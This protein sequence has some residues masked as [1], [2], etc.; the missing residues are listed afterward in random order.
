MTKSVKLD[1][2]LESRIQHLAE[3]RQR[4]PHWIMREAIQQYVDREEKREA[5]R[6]DALNAWEAYQETGLHV[7][8]DEAIAW[9]ETWG[10]E[11][12]K[13]APAC[14]KTLKSRY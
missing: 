13:P 5:F 6:R 7:T 12:E 9:L 3:L 11:N 14:H 8:G 4:S 1:P 2:E 10:E